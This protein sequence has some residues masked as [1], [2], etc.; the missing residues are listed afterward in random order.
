MKMLA[1]PLLCVALAS[2]SLLAEESGTFPGIKALMSPGEYQAAGLDKLSPAELEALDRFLIRYTAEDAVAL[3]A[4][5][6]EVQKAAQ[7][8][9][10]TS[11]IQQPFRGWSGDTIFA[12]ENGQVWKQRY[13]GKYRYTGSHPEV[14]I[15]QN[16]MGFFRME[17]IENGKT[18]QVKRLK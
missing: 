4:S 9:V 16:F 15:T 13:A 11:V 10:I 12:L 2:P 6:E 7:E 5:D 1:Y 18:I 8:Q 3:I 17:L 14:R